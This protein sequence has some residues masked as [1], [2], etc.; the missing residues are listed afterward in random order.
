[1]KHIFFLITALFFSSAHADTTVGVHLWSKHI[2]AH[3][4]QNNDNMGLYARVDNVQVGVYK[5]TLNRYTAYAGYVQPI[6]PVDVMVGV[7]SGYKTHCTTH[8]VVEPEKLEKRLAGQERPLQGAKTVSSWEECYGFSKHR[9]TPTMAV[10]YAAPEVLGATPR[11]WL[12]PG[13]GKGSSV[14]HLSMEWKL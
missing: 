4:Y 13:L 2:P 9:L 12:L 11:I 14:V 5:N 8:S 3:A 10:S 1:M 6:G 7:A